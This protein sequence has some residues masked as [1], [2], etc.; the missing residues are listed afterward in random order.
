MMQFPPFSIKLESL[1]SSSDVDFTVLCKYHWI[2]DWANKIVFPCSAIEPLFAC[3]S[4]N[5]YLR[6]HTILQLNRGIL[7]KGAVSQQLDK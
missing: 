3:S 5:S 2:P 4:S 7:K 6:A 1:I